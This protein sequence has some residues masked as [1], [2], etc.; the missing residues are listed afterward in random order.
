ME[1]GS[2]KVK[3]ESFGAVV[4]SWQSANMDGKTILSENGHYENKLLKHNN[5]LFQ[6]KP[7][8]EDVSQRLNETLN[9]EML[10]EEIPIKEVHEQPG[11]S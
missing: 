2:H 1:E 7:N 10:N 4:P 3:R 8:E 9:A 5:E 6:P 11:Q